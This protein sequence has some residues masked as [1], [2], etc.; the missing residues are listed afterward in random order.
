[1]TENKKPNYPRGIEIPHWSSI[2]IDWNQRLV[3]KFVKGFKKRGLPVDPW[4]RHVCTL[5][6]IVLNILILI[7]SF[8]FYRNYY[9]IW[10]YHKSPWYKKYP[11]LR[12]G[13]LTALVYVV[14]MHHRHHQPVA[15]SV[16]KEVNYQ[17]LGEINGTVPPFP[18][19]T[20]KHHYGSAYH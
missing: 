12:T 13:L 17:V 1:M 3:K 9:T 7:Y 8:Y 2:K 11:I 6:I 16:Y 14:Y 18:H 15:D 5:Q 4:I 20:L 19:H 10:E